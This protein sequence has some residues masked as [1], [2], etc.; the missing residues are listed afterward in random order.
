MS[1]IAACVGC[2]FCCIKTPCQVSMRLYPSVKYCPQLIWDDEKGRYFCG[3]MI[4]EGLIGE[5]YRKELYAG[6]GCCSS[7]NSWRNDVKKREPQ[8]NRTCINPLP[9]IMQIF[10]KCLAGN[11]TSTT[12]IKIITSQM[13]EILLDKGY[14]E[15]EIKNILTN[16]IHTFE[17]NQSSFMKSFMG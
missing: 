1:R 16:I 8:L 12:Q 9:E 7:L 10:I 6:E 5:G 11:F 2:G 4:I 15:N 17:E 14:D 3:L 13:A